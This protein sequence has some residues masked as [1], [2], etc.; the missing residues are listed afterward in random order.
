[1]S[2]EELKEKLNISFKKYDMMIIQEEI[3]GDEIR[4]LVFKGEV[5][6]AINRIP[7][8]IIWDGKKTIEELI[9][10]ENKNP[11]RWEGYNKPLAYIKIDDELVS[12]IG[13]NNF[14]LLSIPKKWEKVQ[15]RGNSNVWTG[16]IIIDV[17][18]KLSNS[19]KETCIQAAQLFWL[20]ICWVDIL[21]S[22]ITQSLEE[23]KGVILEL[24]AT[25]WI[26]W[27]KQFTWINTA[28]III[29]KLFFND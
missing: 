10:K 13:K 23:K 29:E 3:Q 17:K 1:M 6:V 21:T 5:I 24:N 4:V 7:A 19:I 22:D 25:P 8:F 20:E 11:L 14:T 27:D 12:F 28:G 15:L 2:I 18:N 9:E 26:W 16:G